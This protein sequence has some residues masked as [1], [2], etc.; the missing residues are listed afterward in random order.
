MNK[1][2]ENQ[3]V[4]NRRLGPCKVLKVFNEKNNIRYRVRAFNDI[5]HLPGNIAVLPECKLERAK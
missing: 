3:Q 1:F 2:T 4:F 5:Q